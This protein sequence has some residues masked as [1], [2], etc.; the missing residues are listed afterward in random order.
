M[1]HARIVS[2]RGSLYVA[3]EPTRLDLDNLRTH[4]HAL[5]PFPGASVQ[6]ELILGRPSGRASGKMSAWIEEL[7]AE[8][9]RVT[10]KEPAEPRARPRPRAVASGGR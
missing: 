7:M 8:G 9:V 3:A 6:L 10:L 5:Q 4:I 1:F 2:S